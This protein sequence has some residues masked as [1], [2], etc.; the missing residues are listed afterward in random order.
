GGQGH[1]FA[2][3]ARRAAICARMIDTLERYPMADGAI[4]DGP[5]WGYEIAP[6]HMNRRS[7]I[8]DDLPPSVAPKCADLGYDYDALVAAKDRL[9]A[10][11]QSLDPRRIALH[12]AGGILG[13]FQLFGADPELAAWLEF[14]VAALTDFFRGVRECLSSE[15]S[16]PVRL[17]VGPRS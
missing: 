13:A 15:M 3:P 12:A 5:E 7:C 2:D 8:F 6:H 17:G 16:R 9:L 4:M 14:R 10:C 1:V 11:L